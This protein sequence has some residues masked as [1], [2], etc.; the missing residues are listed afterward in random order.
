MIRHSRHTDPR[1]AA[2][3]VFSPHVSQAGRRRGKLGH[4]VSSGCDWRHAVEIAARTSLEREVFRQAKGKYSFDVSHIFRE[5]E[6]GGDLRGSA[7]AVVRRSVAGAIFKMRKFISGL[8]TTKVFPNLLVKALPGITGSH[9]NPDFADAHPDLCAD[10]E[11]FRA[12]RRYLRLRQFGRL[13]PQ[14]S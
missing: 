3:T 4:L 7:G 6:T 5:G 11:Q 8:L 10:L 13:Q 14:P 12:D 2:L 9:R 1:R